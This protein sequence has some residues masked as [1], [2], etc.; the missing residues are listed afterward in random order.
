[1]KW[2]IFE[3]GDSTCDVGQTSWIQGENA[4]T[5]D[6]DSWFFANEVIVKWPKDIGRAKKKMKREVDVD[7]TIT[8]SERYPATIVKFGGLCFFLF[9]TI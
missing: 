7:I 3:F 1:M 5:F 8:E 6:N 4:E 9:L 2:A